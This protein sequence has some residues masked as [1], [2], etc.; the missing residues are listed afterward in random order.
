MRIGIGRPLDITPEPDGDRFRYLLM[1][2]R[3]GS[4]DARASG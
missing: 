3:A 2:I 1:P 4:A